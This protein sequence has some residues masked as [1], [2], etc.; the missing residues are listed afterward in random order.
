[1]ALGELRG[2]V[3]GHGERMRRHTMYAIAEGKGGWWI[4]QV[5]VDIIDPAILRDACNETALMRWDGVIGRFSSHSEA[6]HAAGY[7]VKEG[8][9]TW[10]D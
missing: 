7:A 5:G 3:S 8:W 9:C 1:M 2:K 10:R 6:R 4:A